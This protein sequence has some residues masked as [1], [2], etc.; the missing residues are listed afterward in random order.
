MRIPITA[1]LIPALSATLAGC[2]RYRAEPLDYA[3]AARAWSARSPAA[4]ELTAYA[5]RHAGSGGA[6]GALYDPADGL[7]LA[8]AEV[9][10]LFFNPQLRLARLRADVTRVGAAEAGRWEDPALGVDAERI[11]ASVAKPWVIAG[12]LSLTL[13]VSGRLTLEKD[14]AAADAAVEKL[15][16]L[17]EERSA[18]ADLRDEWLQWSAARERVELTNSL[19]RELQQL[20]AA[21]DTLR[22][23]GELASTDARLFQ[24]EHAAN[25]SRLQSLEADIRDRELGLRARLG[26][27]PDAPVMLVPDLRVTPAP[28][29]GEADRVASS[30]TNARLRLAAAEYEAAERALRLE[31]RK[32]Y[33]DL[34]VRGGYGTDEG[35]ERALLGG[36]LPLPL[37]NGNRRA[38]AEARARRD[39][40]RAAAEAEYQGVVS[41]LA[42][43]RERHAAAERRLAFVRDVLAPLG[44]QQLV[45]LRRL[46]Q[47]GD[48]NSLLLLE[49]SKAAHGVR[50]EVLAARLDASQAINRLNA[51]LDGANPEVRP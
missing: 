20:A 12:S 34:G 23:A 5:R 51:L 31:V 11:L 47:L 30:E 22:R 40:A 7:S 45:D 8:E 42:R 16:V 27:T 14:R 35:D 26:L 49:A 37:L 1:L 33:P 44:E 48:F 28:S 19:L 15:R 36:S 9:V 18:L 2:Q 43:A 24:I 6:E 13:P 41:A 3:A 38:I 46:G 4:D 17:V 32:Q 10:A 39:A 21:A 29:D 25:Q 50:L